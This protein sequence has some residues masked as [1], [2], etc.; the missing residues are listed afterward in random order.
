[1]S[2]LDYAVSNKHVETEDL[3]KVLANE[4]FEIAD[5]NNQDIIIYNLKGKF[6]ISNKDFNLLSQ[7]Q[8]PIAIVNRILKSDKRLDF[9]NYDEKTEGNVT[10]SYMILKN[11]MLEPIGI[12]YFPYYHNDRSYVNVFNK[13]V[14]YIVIVNLFIIAFAV[15]LS[16]IISIILL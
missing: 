5:I 3:P 7:K 8:I 6:L 10:S 14:N 13:Y 16:W 1:M 12:V 2:S 9:Q 4:I 15:W 11:N